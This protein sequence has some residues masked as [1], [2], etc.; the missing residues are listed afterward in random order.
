[1]EI[2]MFAVNTQHWL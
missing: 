2:N 1:M